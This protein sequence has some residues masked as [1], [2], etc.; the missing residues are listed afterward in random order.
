MLWVENIE[1]IHMMDGETMK[2]FRPQI[3]TAGMNSNRVCS[4]MWNR[5]FV[6][7]L[8]LME[9]EFVGCA[10]TNK[11]TARR[12]LR[13]ARGLLKQITGT[14]SR[15]LRTPEEFEAVARVRPRHADTII[16]LPLRKVVSMSC[17]YLWYC[18]SLDLLVSIA[19]PPS[20]Y[21]EL[22]APSSVDYTLHLRTVC[23]RNAILRIPLGPSPVYEL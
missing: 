9:F 21:A 10:G 7:N 2:A 20:A 12:L 15:R 11:Q 16:D 6:K 4:V 1:G 19:D 5:K 17:N 3:Q 8:R 18:V 14:H 22:A 23:P 13:L